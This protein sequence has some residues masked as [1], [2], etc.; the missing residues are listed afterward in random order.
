MDRSHIFVVASVALLGTS[1]AANAGPCTDQ[2]S[3]LEH[4]VSQ[5]QAA[6]PPSGAAEPTARQTVAAQLHHQPTPGA[7]ERAARRANAKA[8]AALAR[9][10][11]ADA[12]GD[13]DGCFKALR[14][15]RDLYGL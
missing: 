6:P 1:V 2:I 12:A 4:Q 8:D 15:A 14:E 11:K 13:A 10:R 3:Q 5:L 7:V 9:A